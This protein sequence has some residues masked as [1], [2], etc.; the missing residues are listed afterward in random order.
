MYQTSISS[1]EK[2]YKDF[3]R[4]I[5]YRNKEEMIAVLG[6]LE[7]NDFLHTMQHE[8]ETFNSDLKRIFSGLCDNTD[9][10]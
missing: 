4:G 7:N 6:T 3:F 10:K 8:T 2:D 5:T 9:K 1:R